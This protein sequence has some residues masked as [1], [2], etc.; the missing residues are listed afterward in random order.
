MF[1]MHTLAQHWSREWGGRRLWRGLSEI[2]FTWA[3]WQRR[4]RLH[5]RSDWFFFFTR[6]K[7]NNINA[8][9]CVPQ[10][11]SAPESFIGVEHAATWIS[12]FT[13]GDSLHVINQIFT[14]FSPKNS[15]FAHSWKF[16]LSWWIYQT[17]F[18]FPAT[19]VSSTEIWSGRTAISRRVLSC[20]SSMH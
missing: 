4:S 15:L 12:F 16:Q 18:T 1:L 7:V 11:R 5:L 13:S 19:K 17:S 20:Q 8:I 9:F 10:R 6:N 14:C 3:H 2:S